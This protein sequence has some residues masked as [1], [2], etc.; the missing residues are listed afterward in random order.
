LL[1]VLA[2]AKIMLVVVVQAV[3]VRRLLAQLVAVAHQ[4]KQYFQRQRVLVTRLRLALVVR[5]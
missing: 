5:H 2:V 1:A 3:I 4:P